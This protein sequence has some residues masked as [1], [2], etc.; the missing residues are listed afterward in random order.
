VLI[1]EGPTERNPTPARS[2]HRPGG[3]A[4]PRGRCGARAA[5]AGFVGTLRAAGAGAWLLLAAL[6]SGCPSPQQVVVKLQGAE[7]DALVT[8]DDEYVD[9]LGVLARRGIKLPRGTYRITV[10]KVGYFPWDRLVQVGDE[11]L[12]LAVKLVPIPD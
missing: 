3:A 7:Q 2:S 8:I 10:E 1:G 6:L 9:K 4:A 12:V 11:P 5:A